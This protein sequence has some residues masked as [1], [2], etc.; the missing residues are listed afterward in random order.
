MKYSSGYVRKYAGGFTL[1]ETLVV[2]FIF[3]IVMM[4]VT[5]FARNTFYTNSVVKGSFSTAQDAEAI[6][7]TITAQLRS[8]SQGS[9]GSYPILSA[10]SSTI[11][12]FSDIY[13]NGV[14][15][16]VRYFLSSTTLEEGIMVPKG[17]PP[18]YANATETISYIAYNV[19]NNGSS[20]NTFDYYDTTYN[21]TSTPL[22]QPV[23]VAAV[24]LVKVTL[25]L[26]SDPN[27]SPTPRTYT[28]QVSLR[29]LK[30]N[31]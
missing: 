21:G 19:R 20:T 6:L 2:A 18:S 28:T 13:G 3:V 16:R 30:D 23:S 8:A 14:K 1:V 5:E 25:I 4:G 17:T 31:L 10:G 15:E 9:D 11:T 24:R 29:N 26:D 22:T 12:F 27:R 7:R